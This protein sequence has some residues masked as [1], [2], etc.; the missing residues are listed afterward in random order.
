MY[1]Y[2]DCSGISII[3]DRNILLLKKK[4]KTSFRFRLSTGSNDSTATGS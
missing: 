3:S 4:K 2:L 1:V